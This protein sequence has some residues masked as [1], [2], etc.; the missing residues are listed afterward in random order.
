MSGKT[1][2]EGSE[3]LPPSVEEILRA[4]PLNPFVRLEMKP[5]PESWSIVDLDKRQ[6]AE[7]EASRFLSV[8]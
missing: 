7:R 8:Q 4:Q 3:G 6:A 5:L 1:T 2:I